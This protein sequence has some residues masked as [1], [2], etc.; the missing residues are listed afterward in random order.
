MLDRHVSTVAHDGQTK[1]WLH[2]RPFAFFACFVA[3]VG[4]STHLEKGK[5]ALEFTKS[6]S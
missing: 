5:F 6:K 4:S 2:R 3:T 1:Q